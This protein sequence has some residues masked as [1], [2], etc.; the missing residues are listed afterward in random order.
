VA[1]INDPVATLVRFTAYNGQEA[2]L[3]A[4]GVRI[5][6]PGASA[7]QDLEPEYVA[8]D[9]DET[10]A[11]VT[12]QENNALAVIDIPS[13][14]VRRIVTL[15]CKSHSVSALDASDRDNAVNIRTYSVPLLGMYQ[16]DAIAA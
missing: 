7:A 12:L 13:A 2:S 10:T 3:R 5:F 4:Q 1:N 6:G 8:V 9:D 11:W 16:P 15:G 14:S